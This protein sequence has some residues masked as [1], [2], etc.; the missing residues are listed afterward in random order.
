MIASAS[1]HPGSTGGFSGQLIYYDLTGRTVKSSNPTE[2]SASSTSDNPYDWPATGDDA[3]AG[4]MYTQQT[5]DWKGRPLVTTNTDNTTKSASYGGCGCAGGE[6]VTLTDETSRQQKVY[7]DVLGRQ[8][9][10]QVL[11][12]DSTVYSTTISTFN[13]RDQ[14]MLVRQYQGADTSSTYQ[15]TTVTYDGYGRLLTKHVPE[16][17]TGTSTVYNY[18]PDDSI[19]SVTDARGASATYSYNNRRLV[20]G[21][22]Y[23]APAGITPTS[24]V[25]ISYDAAGNRTSMTDGFGS[26]TYSYNQL[27]QLMSEARTFTNVGTFTLSYDY[28]L[29]GQLKKITDPMNVTINYGFDSTGRLSS[30]TGSDTLY[31]A[32]SNYASNLQY[33]AW[34]AAK[35]LN[36]G[37]SLTVDLAYNNRGQTTQYDLKTAGGAEVFGLQYQYTSTPT[38]TDND[39]RLKYSHDLVNSNLD[40][41][42]SYD[43]AARLTLGD[44]AN[45]SLYGPYKQ[46][47]GYDV[48]ENLTNRS[49]RTFYYNQYCHCMVPQTNYSSSNYSN[50]RNTATGWNYDA[51]G[52]LLGSV[53]GGTNFTYGFDAAGQLISTTAP[54]KTLSQSLD[55]DG[56]KAKWVENG[57]TTFYVRSS[58]LGG[59]TIVE[60]DQYGNKVRGYVYGGGQEIAKQ[61]AG[62]VLWDQRDVSG[63]S[64]RLTNSSG[65]VASKVETDPLGT[66]VS[67]TSAFNQN[68]GGNGYG[69]NPNGFY[70]DPTMPS[71]GCTGNGSA[72]DCSYVMHDLN[73]R[74][75]NRCP[76]GV[77]DGPSP[78][79]GWNAYSQRYE[80]MHF[81]PNAAAAGIGVGGVGVGFLPFGFSFTGSGFTVAPGAGAFISGM[82]SLYPAEGFAAGGATAFYSLNQIEILR[83]RSLFSIAPQKTTT[84]EHGITVY[85]EQKDQ[86]GG[87]YLNPCAAEVFEK[88]GFGKFINLDN[89]RIHIGIPSWITDIAKKAGGITPRA[90]TWGNDI[91]FRSAADFDFNPENVV[92]TLAVIGHE[93][94]HVLQYKIYKDS[95]YM[96]YLTD[97]AR[98]GFR[99]GGKLEKQGEQIEDALRKSIPQRLGSDPCKDWRH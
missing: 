63:V 87:S 7:S 98:S 44:T 79:V 65:G 37:N 75:Q 33:R 27:S 24:N 92:D 23:S 31:A 25:S 99:Y 26:K 42:Y 14:V 50:N 70:G 3:V 10:M 72:T 41:T 77:C 85:I 71:M 90:I 32:V 8:W 46:T 49:W 95:F 1:D 16:Q 91:Y 56:L 76:N 18:N 89:V 54:G 61:E 67:D 34:G 15:D 58:A 51:D 30:V 73:G 94:E 69:F 53:D 62:Q 29:A 86:R 68:G 45:G 20:T 74:D 96:K 11:N 22:T 40:R 17:S 6:V 57:V 84:E 5:Y 78:V 9:K 88:L 48:W 19:N 47:Y 21:M 93:L 59:Q 80:F 81:D 64:M 12:W 66:Q 4:W 82:G 2:T 55:G 38:S 36:Y 13:A 43:Q 97:W 35:H 28:N 60:L 83:P 39:G 52:R